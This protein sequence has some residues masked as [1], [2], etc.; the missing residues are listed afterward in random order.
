M[1]KR[2]NVFQSGV[3]DQ[4]LLSM[5]GKRLHLGNSH[6]ALSQI[7]QCMNLLNQLTDFNCIRHSAILDI[8]IFQKSLETCFSLFKHLILI[9]QYIIKHYISALAIIESI[10]VYKNQVIRSTECQGRNQTF[11]LSHCIP[12]WCRTIDNFCPPNVMFLLLSLFS[13]GYTSCF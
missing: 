8:V 12:L 3:K 9:Y 1:I 7:F 2:S 13:F 11:E 4:V 10:I 6:V 5:P